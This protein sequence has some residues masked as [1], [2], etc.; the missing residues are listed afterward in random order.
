MDL[1]ILTALQKSLPILLR[2]L[3]GYIELAERDWAA[4]KL[5]VKGRMQTW[6][7]LIFAIFF[8]LGA[9]FMFVVGATWDGDYRLLA[10][11]LLCGVCVAVAVGAAARLKRQR[12][13]DAF[14]A[15]RREWERDREVVQRLLAESHSPSG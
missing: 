13:D 6:A 5:S 14:A 2:H 4:A 15:V 1:R 12:T 11:G 9:A 3:D 7:V 8:A 10:I